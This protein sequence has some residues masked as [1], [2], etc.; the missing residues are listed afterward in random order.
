MRKHSQFALLALLVTMALPPWATPELLSSEAGESRISREDGSWIEEVNGTLTGR[1]LHVSTQIGNI[2]VT[3]G[4]QPNITYVVKKRSYSG[5]EESARRQLASF[6][7]TAGHHGE[8]AFIEGQGE[9]R[10]HRFAVEF[11]IQVP[12]SIELVKLDTEGGNVTVSAIGGRVETNT[13][14]GNLRMDDVAGLIRGDSGG[15]NIEI[16]NSGSE[17]SLRT[18]GGNIHIRSAKGRVSAST[19]GGRVSVDSGSQNM[20]LET[21]GGTID[22]TQ[23]GGELKVSTGGGNIHLGDIVGKAVVE[24]GGGS[25]RLSSAQGPVV[26]RTGGGSVE[27]F[28][29]TQGARIE[30]GGGSITAEFVGRGRGGESSIQTGAGDI[31]VY[32]SPQL[33]ITVR[34]S[35]EMANG[36]RIHSDFPEFKITSEG[37]TYDP[38]TV[39]AEG[40]LNGGGP[41]LR[42]RTAVG[43]IDVRK[44]SK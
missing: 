9:G 31:V 3:G 19:G 4:S 34:A 27:L 38:R 7:I 39:F 24:T 37:G 12:R 8:T 11:S 14:G 16:G 32:L 44:A 21:G 30:T 43:D 41:L 2:T 18:G 36:H 29:L 33:A 26:A 17:V 42:I 10:A 1:I 15:G 28:K 13:G 22:V 6:R 25:I 5:A 23:C 20:I 35:I 40:S